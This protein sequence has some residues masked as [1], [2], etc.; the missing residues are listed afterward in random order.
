MSRFRVTAA[1]LCCVASV[2]FADDTFDKLVQSGKYQEAIEYADQKIPAGARTAD[3]WV[4]LADANEK[5]G[6]T[7]KALACYMVSWRMNPNDYA[8]LLGAARIYNKLNQPDNAMDMAKKALE[9]N[10]T[11]EASWEYAR[12]CIEL[13]RPADAK[14]AL[15]KVIETEPGNLVANREL[16]HIY[17]NDRQYAQAVP[18]LKKAYEAKPDADVAFKIGKCYVES[19]NASAAVDYLKKTIEQRPTYYE[20][21]LELARAYFA[22]D[23]KLAAASEYDRIDKK[24]KFTPLDYYKMGVSF[25]E[26]GKKDRAIAAYREAIAGYGSSKD[27]EAMLA[28]QKVGREDLA[29]KNYSSALSQFQF[30][31]AADP[32]A[33]SVN[34]I[35]FLLADAYL[36][37]K[38][39]P[40]AIES[41]EKAI[42]LNKTNI[43]AY[44]RLADLYRQNNMH[45][46]AKK[47]YETMMSLRPD[48][49]NVFLILGEYNLKA[50][51]FSE[52]LDYYTK[53]NNLRKSAAAL[54]GMALCARAL[55]QWDKARDAAES[56]V[57][58]DQS[59]LDSRKVLAEAYLR[60]NLFR[61]AVPHLEFIAGKEPGDIKNWTNLAIC[62]EKTN[63][64]DKLAD[65]DSKIIQLDGKNADSRLR[66]A[67][68]SLAKG[69]QETAYKLLKE[70]AVLTPRDASVFKNLYEIA[71]NKKE[72]AN[73]VTYLK[74]YLALNPNDAESQRDLGDL[75]YERKELDGALD[76]YRMA[77]KIDPAIKGF[78]KRYADIVIAK[79]QQD[80]VI[81]ALSGVIKA[82]E[83]DLGTYTTL[84]MIYQKK[85]LYKNAIEMYEKAL[86]LDP[87]NTDALVALGDCQAGMGNINDAVITYEQAVMMNTKADKEYKTL[88]DLYMRQ[89]KTEQAY[90]AYKKYLN[91]GVKDE[92]VALKVGLYM[93]DKKNYDE[94]KKYL[95]MVGGAAANDAGYLQALGEACFYTG[96]L[97][98]AIQLFKNLLSRN[99]KTPKASILLMLAQAYEKKK[100]NTSAVAY[101]NQYLETGARD[102]DVAFRRA[103]MEESLNQTMNAEK[104]YEQNITLYPGD[105]RNY[106]QLGMMYAK[107]KETA[108]RAVTL[109]QKVTALADTIPSVWLE[110]ARVYGK[111]GKTDD[112]LEAYKQYVK[113]DPQNVEANVRLGMILLDKG[114]LSEGM[115]YL[116]TANTLKPGD[117]QIMLALTSGYMVTKRIGEA[118]SLLNKAKQIKP[119]DNEIRQQLANLYIE[120]GD[121]K[122]AIDEIKEILKTN[123]DNKLLLTYANLLYKEGRTKEA[124]EAI[125]DIRA[126]DPE[127]I[128]A[129][130]TLAL[131]QRSKKKYDEAIETYKEIMY[132]DGNYAPAIFERAE[133][134]ML[135]DKPQWAQKFYERALRADP[136]HALSELGLAKIA[137]LRND[138]AAY[139][140]HLTKA[141]QLDP[142]N[143]DIQDEYKRSQK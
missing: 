92:D 3:I 63:N 31:A 80:E 56:A 138:R 117:L 71:K 121:R 21:G 123:R 4:K 41:L 36:G 67:K 100:D 15:E 33:R 143:K 43:E 34:D 69:D 9:L 68:Y 105:F 120:K 137:K 132:I 135:Q 131:V 98:R 35:Y 89:K 19:G 128:E 95:G 136:N 11:A 46:Q 5:L 126:T 61:D 45:E 115:I 77:I 112:E 86:K 62:Y 52:A 109:L 103:Y 6:L 25:E 60:S 140:M 7:E 94:V 48:D 106:L 141:Y 97:D 134:Y 24:I 37:T 104:H 57:A 16:G 72:A 65:A 42:N 26:S 74:S 23:K 75:L 70:L 129:L 29:N 2:S 27:Q 90:G 59:L 20:A 58:A 119:D 93:Y 84:G 118:E 50:Q 116:E 39:V 64:T 1:V 85:N 114:K 96:D 130:M 38:N 49:P 101:Y 83:A 12:A 18:L 44:A 17:Y 13:K 54:E 14:K 125:E 99:P 111:L 53:S 40:K 139:I 88:G 91:S 124:E 32:S 127:N 122:K 73:A 133:V 142:N 79:G 10:F 47:T 66:Y 102:A 30:I 110:I 78:Y 107:K 8:S 51:K 108:M 28:R 22:M 113:S 82:G 87:Q 76:A 55:G 81:K